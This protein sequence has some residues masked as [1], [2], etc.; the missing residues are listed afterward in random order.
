MFHNEFY[1]TPT[2]V[3]EMMQLDCKG[4]IILEPHAGFGHI[5][6]Y[7]KNQGAKEVIAIEINERCRHILR[8]K[9]QIIGEDFFQCKPEDISHIDTIIMNPPF[10]N[11]E[12]HFLRNW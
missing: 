5:V 10:S 3:L 7:C 12:K 11:A 6:E 1:P 9:C 8:S 4:K 2:D